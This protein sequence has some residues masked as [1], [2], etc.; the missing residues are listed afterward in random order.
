MSDYKTLILQTRLFQ[1]PESSPL[2]ELNQLEKSSVFVVDPTTMK[3]TD[4]DL[5]LQNIIDHDRCLTL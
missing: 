2:E 4:W 5:V 3:A 1:K